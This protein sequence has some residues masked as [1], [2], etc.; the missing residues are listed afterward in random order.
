MIQPTIE[1]ENIQERQHSCKWYFDE[2]VEVYNK[3]WGESGRLSVALK[4]LDSFTEN[5]IKLE[6][7]SLSDQGFINK[8]SNLYREL[9][10]LEE[11]EGATSIFPLFV[12]EIKSDPSQLDDEKKKQELFEKKKFEICKTLNA[13]DSIV[14]R[15]CSDNVDY[16]YREKNNIVGAE[17]VLKWLY[18]STA[19]GFDASS[20]KDSEKEE[21]LSEQKRETPRQEYDRA[22]VVLR[23]IVNWYKKQKEDQQKKLDQLYS[24][25]TVEELLK[26]FDVSDEPISGNCF[27]W[28]NDTCKEKL[29][30][31]IKETLGKTLDDVE[32]TYKKLDGF[33]RYAIRYEMAKGN[34]RKEVELNKL[35]SLAYAILNFLLSIC[36]AYMRINQLQLPRA[37]FKGAR[38]FHANISGSNFSNANFRHV[39]M[40]YAIAQNCDFSFATLRDA[41]ATNADFSKSLFSYADLSGAD[42]SDATINHVKMDAVDI[43]VYSVDQWNLMLGY[44]SDSQDIKNKLGQAAVDAST[45]KNKTE[46]CFKNLVSELNALTKKQDNSYLSSDSMGSLCTGEYKT[47]AESMVAELKALSVDFE[48]YKKIQALASLAVKK[49]QV[50][51]ESASIKDSKLPDL[52]LSLVDMK[53]TSFNDSDLSG[54]KFAY[55]CA[56]GADFSRANMA[57]AKA[58]KAHFEN[59]T[60]H[61]ALLVNMLLVDCYMESVNFTNANLTNVH[62]L[63]TSN[64]DQ[65]YIR[66]TVKNKELSLTEGTISVPQVD[67]AADPEQDVT[68]NRNNTFYGVTASKIVIAGCDFARSTFDTAKFRSSI[69]FDVDA[70]STV[71]DDADLMSSLVCGVVFNRSSMRRILLQESKIYGSDFSC[72]NLSE[73]RLLSSTINKA[74]FYDSNLT[75]A[76]LSHTKIYN[77]VFRASAADGLNVSYTEFENCLFLEIDFSTFVGLKNAKFKDCLFINCKSTSA[78]EDGVMQYGADGRGQHTLQINNDVDLVCKDADFKGLLTNRFSTI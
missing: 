24:N 1:N 33:R 21:T 4:K 18:T 60:F 32:E 22:T 36:V 62:L 66:K 28:N 53:F 48:T 8:H 34:M 71:W 27:D 78:S 3:I 7:N 46:R 9:L 42:F 31:Q 26:L 58:Y 40:P 45:A 38:L 65:E 64:K 30:P 50:K 51:L 69:L 5:S 35:L 23:Q 13:I 67:D 25:K 49:A 41:R 76:N 57:G 55:S 6:R 29:L 70:T 52:N 14:S 43:G 59:T 11:N 74:V 63:N 10:M 68:I 47:Y 44:N 56:E 37:D 54:C 2:A 19:Q 72:C 77:T 16:A 20:A 12:R 75:K 17:T 61:Q 73:A 15:L 39:S